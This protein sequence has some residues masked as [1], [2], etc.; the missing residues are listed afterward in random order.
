MTLNK[1]SKTEIVEYILK[2]EKENTEEEEEKMRR[3][4][5]EKKMKEREPF[6]L[7]KSQLIKVGTC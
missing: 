3:R 7:V 4:K 6:T 2:K 5:K 1:S